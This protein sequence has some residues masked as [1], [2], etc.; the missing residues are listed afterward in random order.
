MQ[1]EKAAQHEQRDWVDVRPEARQQDAER[2]GAEHSQHQPTGYLLRV[3]WHLKSVDPPLFPPSLAVAQ[4]HGP[5]RIAQ[6]QCSAATP[7]HS[8]AVKRLRI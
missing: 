8:M 2:T 5:L 6:S 1:E 7:A 3:P 4:C